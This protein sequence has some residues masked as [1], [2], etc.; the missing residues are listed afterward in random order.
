MMMRKL[1]QIIPPVIKE[2]TKRDSRPK[3]RKE[4][5]A[6]IKA[7]GRKRKQRGKNERQKER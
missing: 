4:E 1:A 6:E 7:I 2:E 5:H 3:D